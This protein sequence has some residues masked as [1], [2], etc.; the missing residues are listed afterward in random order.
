MFLNGKIKGII[1]IPYYFIKLFGHSGSSNHQKSHAT[2]A[3]LEKI[4]PKPAKI[5][6]IKFI[7][8]PP[9]FNQIDMIC[10]YHIVDLIVCR[11]LEKSL[12]TVRLTQINNN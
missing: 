2:L 12:H 3:L 5:D 8:I 10:N 9:I 4:P 1:N 7:L 11:L 6:V